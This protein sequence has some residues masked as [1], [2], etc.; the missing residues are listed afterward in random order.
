MT[1]CLAI[2]VLLIGLMSLPNQEV[3]IL[4]HP[5]IYIAKLNIE[6]TMAS[7]IVQLAR[8]GRADA[9]RHHP[10]SQHHSSTPRA[11]DST[12]AGQRQ[13]DIIS[14]DRGI[15]MKNFSESRIRASCSGT[16]DS[17]AEEFTHGGI[18]RT[19]EFQ[20]TV[21][22]SSPGNSPES[23]VEDTKGSSRLEDEI[24]LTGSHAR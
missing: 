1:T 17:D 16:R 6:M 4:F 10:A 21:H 11:R 20:V 18:Q 12:A 22:H 7:L 13:H 9:Y 23:M 14:D 3:F 19:T 8:T 2:Q 15:A 24:W 5:L